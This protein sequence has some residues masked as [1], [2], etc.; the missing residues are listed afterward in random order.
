MAISAAAA[1]I[2]FF[3]IRNFFSQKLTNTFC[4]ELIYKLR[5]H[6]V[7]VLYEASH[8]VYFDYTLA[9]AEKWIDAAE[10]LFQIKGENIEDI[11]HSDTL[12]Y[13]INP[14]NASSYTGK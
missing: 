5:E 3:M 12:T 14:R 13:R 6:K 2:F 1:S 7:S 11:L 8:A 9:N 4:K 10:K